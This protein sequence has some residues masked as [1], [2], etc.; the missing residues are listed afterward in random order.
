M[1]Q[2]H[3]KKVKNK[4]YLVYFITQ[5]NIN[6]TKLNKKIFYDKKLAKLAL[7]IPRT[8]WLLN[9][10]ILTLSFTSLDDSASYT[11]CFTT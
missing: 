9:N 4:N 2:T 1:T 6:L 11:F 10:S 5:W 3:K 7:K 8:N